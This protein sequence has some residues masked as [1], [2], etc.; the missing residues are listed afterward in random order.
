MITCSNLGFNGRFGNQLFQFSAV[1]GIAEKLNHEAF[2]SRFNINY[3][4]NQV[5]KNGVVFDA[6]IDIVNCFDINDNYFIENLRI[7]NNYNEPFFHFDENVFNLPDNTD[8]NGYFQ[9]EKYFSHCSE[10]ILNILKIKEDVLKISYSLI[11]NTEKKL[12]G[13]HVRR[14]DYLN[15]SQFHPWVGLEYLNNS[16]S[17]FNSDDYHF[18]VCSDDYHWCNEQWGNNK[19]FTVIKSPSS[20]VDFAVLTLCDHHIISNSSFSWWSS[21]LSKNKNKKVIAPKSWFGESYTQNNTKDLYR[22]DMIII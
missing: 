11:P 21:Y 9:S 20:Y 12:V 18:V 13:I 15:L 10:K 7:N 22:N 14:G 1:I 8:I 6:K 5:L 16:I 4:F 3:G 2:F 17:L 19:D